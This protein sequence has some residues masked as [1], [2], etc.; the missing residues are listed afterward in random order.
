MSIKKFGS[1][2]PKKSTPAERARSLFDPTS[3]AEHK[4]KSGL[5]DR[6]Y[7]DGEEPQEDFSVIE[8]V[9]GTDNPQALINSAERLAVLYSAAQ[10]SPTRSNI[11]A[12]RNELDK[13]LASDI[14]RGVLALVV[15][16]LVSS[17]NGGKGGKKNP[18][19][20]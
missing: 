9:F 5:G 11:E 13:V 7:V 1:E 10:R 16:S 18:F 12:F 19:N 8:S 15:I 2:E 17:M 14:A 20:L 6:V 4:I 3:P